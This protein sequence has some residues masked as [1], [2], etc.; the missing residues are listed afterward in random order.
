MTQE[1][2]IR[3][4]YPTVPGPALAEYIGVTRNQLSYMVHQ[5]GVKKNPRIKK[6]MN[7]QRIK[8]AHEKL[9]QKKYATN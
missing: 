1:Q 2:L 7:Q 5:M 3:V 8:Q 4:L 6:L 9:K